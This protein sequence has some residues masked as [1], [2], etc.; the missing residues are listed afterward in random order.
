[1]PGLD[2][3]KELGLVA[4]C[5]SSS[6]PATI[7]ETRGTRGQEQGLFHH[8]ALAKTVV[9]G[10]K[11]LKDLAPGWGRYCGWEMVLR[12]TVGMWSVLTCESPQSSTGPLPNGPWS[13]FFCFLGLASPS[14]SPSGSSLR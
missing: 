9:W 7:A 8:D 11:I 4:G 13:P 14:P 1:M 12:S 3:K 5:L 2:G 10:Q 6:F